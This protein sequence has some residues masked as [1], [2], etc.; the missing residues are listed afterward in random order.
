M[1]LRSL[2]FSTDEQT[3][4]SVGEILASLDVEVESCAQ[5][6]AAVEKL[7]QESFQIV[8]VDWDNQPEAGLL[9]GTARDRKPAERPLTL[10]I[11]SDDAGIPKALQA[12]ANSIL[13]KPIVQSQVR[14]TLKTARDLLRARQESAATA[15][16]AAAGASSAS[17]PASIGGG[18]GPVLRSGEFLPTGSSATQFD[19]ESDFQKSLEQPATA[20]MD[21]LKDLEPMAAAVSDETAPEAPTLPEPQAPVQE[22]GEPHGLE[23]YMNRKRGSLPPVP[24][25]TAVSEATP[26]PAKPEMLGYDQTPSY[27]TSSVTTPRAESL[28]S[29]TDQHAAQDQKTEAKL[30]AYLSGEDQAPDKKPSGQ[31]RLRLGKVPIIAAAILAGCAIV[32]APQAPWHASIRS[33]W[34]RGRQNIQAWLNPQPVTPPQAPVTHETFARAGDEY[35]LPVAENIPDATTDPTQIKVMPVVDPTAK[36]P[37]SDPNVNP[38]QTGVQGETAVATPD[39]EPSTV[40]VQENPGAPIAVAAPNTSA[41][42]PPPTAVVHAETTSL[43]TAA[44]VA[45]PPTP[46]NPTPRPSAGSAP[47]S[48]FN[49]TA[50]TIPSSLKSQ[51]ASMTPDASGNKPLEA[52][53]PSIEPVSVP[54]MSERNLLTEQPPILYPESAKGQQGT[55][56]LQVLIG[57]DGSVQ[58]AKF[59]Q[60]SLAFARA[61]IDG[62]KQWKFKPYTM[63]GRAVSVQTKMT[64]GFKP[65]S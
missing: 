54:E 60:G 30:F 59:L 47:T 24:K 58:D 32:A 6:A 27:A 10:A 19:T 57:R 12:G 46:R 34:A 56:V 63:N 13:R 64:L 50:A 5:A 11:V 14:D 40:Q 17:A 23:W 53:L 38:D 44:A 42:G 43:G 48:A 41:S 29:G 7:T 36:K 45:A 37:T 16:A 18:T 3:A 21:A 35:K 1:A 65:G 31:P 51:I 49:S 55:V 61:A 9:L 22:S 28:E 33:V 20:E 2:L 8:L 52:A 26:A 25:M 39:G 62:V 15:R 4:Q